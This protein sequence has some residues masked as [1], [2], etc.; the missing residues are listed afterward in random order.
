[1]QLAIA[2]FTLT[3]AALILAGAGLGARIGRRR[4]FVIGAIVYS[5][6]SLMTAL[7]S[8]FG[9]LF[10]G[11]SIIEGIGAAMVIPSI[12]TPIKVY[13]SR[14]APMPSGSVKVLRPAAMAY[15]MTRMK[16]QQSF[17]QASARSL[18]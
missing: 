13:N 16:F 18:G 2:T 12:G 8:G 15:V 14:S 7:A 10:V 9:M 5:V 4:T 6:G 1:M 11:W 17:Q 3:M